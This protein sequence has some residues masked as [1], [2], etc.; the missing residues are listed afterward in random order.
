M[1][2]S[3]HPRSSLEYGTKLDAPGM[4]RW[5]F[6]LYP[7]AAEGGG[8]FRSAADPSKGRCDREPPRRQS[9]GR[10]PPGPGQ[11]SPVLRGEPAEPTRHP[12]LRGR[13]AATI[14]PAPRRRRRR[15]SGGSGRRPASG[16]RTCGCPSG[17]PAGTG[18][19]STS[20]SGAT[21]R[22]ARSRR[23][24]AAGFVHIKL[25]GDLPVGSGTLRGGAAGGA[26]PVEVRRQ[27]PRRRARPAGSIGTRSRRASS[28]GR[29]SSTADRGRGARLGRVVHGRGRRST[30]GGRA[31]SEDWAGPPGGVGVVGV[32]RPTPPRCA[33]VGRADVRGAGACR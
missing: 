32:R 8:S 7:D 27:G 30:C 29:S 17:T 9:G 6:V 23:P 4:G 20:R 15:S 22:T 13:R 28:R 19:T 33:G 10:G 16:S 2:A 31:M 14:R 24:G 1:E 3:P 18:S 11:G 12:D 5:G 25:L 21:S 26:V